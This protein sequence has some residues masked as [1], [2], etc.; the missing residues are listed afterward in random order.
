MISESDNAICFFLH[1]MQPTLATKSIQLQNM[2]ICLVTILVAL[3]TKNEGTQR[4]E[5]SDF[6]NCMCQCTLSL[7]DLQSGIVN[8]SDL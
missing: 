4:N 8:M 6:Y 1:P 7:L 3:V 5:K 2:K